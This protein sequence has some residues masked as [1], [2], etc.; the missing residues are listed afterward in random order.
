LPDLVERPEPLLEVDDLA[1]GYG[2][3]PVVSNIQLRVGRGEIV[4]I[5]GPNGAG[6]STLLKALTGN[7]PLMHGSYVL[8]GDEVSRCTADALARRGV[9][10]IPQVDDTFDTLTVQEN[11]VIGGYLLPRGELRGRIE[12]SLEAFPQLH[13]MRTRRGMKL[14][15]GERK[16]LAMARVLLTDPQLVIL[17]E[18]TAG[19]SPQMA[20]QVL[21]EL[22][23]KMS[24]NAAVL[25]VE[26][27]ALEALGVSKWGYVMVAGRIARSASAS[28]LRNSDLAELFL[29]AGPHAAPEPTTKLNRRP[30][31]ATDGTEAN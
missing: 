21:V 18:P 26:Q 28:S 17:D 14:S 8:G 31:G 24:D 12:R 13:E 6:K 10:Y 3:V 11:L 30:T 2:R 1:A 23:P 22:V 25:L 4:S 29:G 19:L 15:G 27:R 9:A 5:I 7:L 16:M 20:N